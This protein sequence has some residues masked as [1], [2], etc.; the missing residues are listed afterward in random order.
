MVKRIFCRIFLL[1]MVFNGYGSA[2]VTIPDTPAGHTLQAW[3]DAF[4]S[5]D[6]AKIEAYVKTIDKKATVDGLMSV[7]SQTGGEDL[8]SI[9]SSEPLRIRFQVK[10]R[11][12][13]IIG[14]GTFTVKDGQ[15]PTVESFMLRALPP[16]AVVEHVT[17]DMTERKKIID[18]VDAAL[19]EFYVDAAVAQQMTDALKAHEAKGD[20]GA[21]TDGDDFAAR[22]TDDMRAVSHDKHLRV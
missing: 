5:D 11:N 3:L 2:Q 20:Y 22:L 6:R 18:G 12:T 4:N 21:I 14:L 16:G 9:V 15:P 10:D 1:M 7:R 8:L 17:M 13:P 19:N